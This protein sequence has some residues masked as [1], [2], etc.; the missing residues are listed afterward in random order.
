[1]LTIA[2]GGP[3]V[4]VVI[5]LIYC[6]FRNRPPKLSGAAITHFGFLGIIT[7][8]GTVS[9]ITASS[10]GDSPIP[11]TLD[12]SEVGIFAFGIIAVIW[13]IAE[14]VSKVIDDS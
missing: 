12:S 13:L 2:F 7:I 9:K 14:S 11:I 5:Y 8:S 3:L 1:M 10:Q 6:R 4:G